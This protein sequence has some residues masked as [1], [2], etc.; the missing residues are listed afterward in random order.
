[1]LHAVPSTSLFD[2][3]DALRARLDLPHLPYFADLRTGALSR[4]GFVAG[5]LQ[6]RFAVEQFARPMCLLATRLADGP[7]RRALLTNIAD[8]HGDGAVE[9]SHTQTFRRFLRRL[10]VADAR[11][12][13]TIAGSAV[14]QFNA[15]L[16]GV[17]GHE[18]PRLALATLGIIEHLFA[19]FSA[20]I[21]QAVQAHG[22]LT[23]ADMVHY[24]THETLD[25]A[26]ARGFLEPLMPHWPSDPEVQAGLE[27]GA[28]A[29]VDLYAALHEEAAQ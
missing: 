26:H 2:A 19:T 23:A 27:L 18:S 16:M 29:F 17:A 22:W 4:A 12:D 9:D 24:T 10:G 5:Q 8:E 7:A 13:A 28:Y 20:W 6:F 1:M 14:R 21:G 15:M 25:I 3:V 11:I